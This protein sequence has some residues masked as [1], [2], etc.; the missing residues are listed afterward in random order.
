MF[1]DDPDDP[2]GRAGIDAAIKRHYAGVGQI[3]YTEFRHFCHDD[4]FLRTHCF[5]DTT[6][7]DAKAHL[8]D[9]AFMTGDK[10]GGIASAAQLRRH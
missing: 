4:E 1:G 5:G 7:V 10:W 6:V 2:R 3:A 9:A 8:R